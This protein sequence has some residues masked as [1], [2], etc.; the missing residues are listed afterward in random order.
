MTCVPTLPRH[1]YFIPETS[2]LKGPCRSIGL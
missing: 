1:G 2:S